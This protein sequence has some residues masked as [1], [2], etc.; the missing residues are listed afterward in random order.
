M[1]PYTVPRDRSSSLFLHKRV[2]SSFGPYTSAK[3]SLL[4]FLLGPDAHEAITVQLGP[5]L[6]TSTRSRASA[7][8]SPLLYSNV[9]LLPASRALYRDRK[10]C[11]QA[12][13]ILFTVSR[14][15][16]VFP[17]ALPDIKPTLG[18]Q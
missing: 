17:S 15:A 2:G 6:V 18:I 8:V 9:P 3:L 12:R 5:C 4:A 1:K 7:I 13:I 14:Q 11:T 16:L 10:R